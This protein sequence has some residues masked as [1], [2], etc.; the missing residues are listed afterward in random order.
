MKTKSQFESDNW[1]LQCL[2]QSALI[3]KLRAE[4]DGEAELKPAEL[5]PCVN[6]LKLTNADAPNESFNNIFNEDD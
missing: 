5:S 2:L 3:K 6:F 4:V 1:E